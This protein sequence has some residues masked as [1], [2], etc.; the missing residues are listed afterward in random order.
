MANTTTKIE[1]SDAMLDDLLERAYNKKNSFKDYVPMDPDLLI[2]LI[3]V[4]RDSDYKGKGIEV[5]YQYPDGWRLGY[6]WLYMGGAQYT[7]QAGSKE[8]VD[9]VVSF[10]KGLGATTQEMHYEL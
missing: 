1:I 9:E 5:K 7:T 4:I 6:V 8:R 2:A 10:W 3:R